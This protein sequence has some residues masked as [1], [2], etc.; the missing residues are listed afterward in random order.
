MLV[1][2]E[3]LSLATNQIASAVAGD[4]DLTSLADMVTFGNGETQKAVTVQVLND[5]IPELREYFTIHLENPQ[6]GQALIN[7]TK[8]CL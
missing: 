7:P 6:G 8:V 4:F 5:N 1:I 3:F 2:I